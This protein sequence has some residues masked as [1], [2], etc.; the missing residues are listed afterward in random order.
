MQPAPTITQS[1]LIPTISIIYPQVTGGIVV[2][3]GG[4]VLVGGWILNIEVL[5]SLFPGLTAMKINT[6]LGLV[7][8]GISLLLL[9]PNVRELR[10]RSKQGFAIVLLPVVI[11]TS[12]KEGQDV[13]SGYQ[14][15]SNSYIRKPVS[16]DEFLEAVLQLGIIG[17]CLI[18][19][20]QGKE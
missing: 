18:R 1:P 4:V 16:F 2:L 12:S 8:C 13:I 3:I 20:C 10:H 9:Q 15:G 5:R 7:S 19:P 14:L 17:C 11:L 6:A